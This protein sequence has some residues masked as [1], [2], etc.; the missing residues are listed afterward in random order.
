MAVDTLP[1]WKAL[2]ARAQAV[3]GQHLRAMFA[4]DADRTARFGRR[5]GPFLLDLSRQR[6][7]GQTLGLLQAFA[8]AAGLQ[9]W[10]GRLF[11]GEHVNHTE[12]QAALH[13]ALRVPA[14]AAFVVDGQ[15]LAPAVERERRRMAAMVSRLHAGHWR[16]YS[17]RAIVDIVNIGVGG[18]DL[19]PAMACEAL[20]D[21]THPD[22]QRLRVHFA[23]SMDGSQLDRLLRVLDPETTLFIVSSKSF[24]T[25]DTLAN[26]R[27][28]R[29]WLLA[30][31]ADEALLLRQ[32]FVA[33]TAS[34]DKAKAWGVSEDNLLLF[35]NWVGGRYSLWSTIGLPIAVQ[36]GMSGFR[37]LLAGA[38]F[39][40]EHFRRAPL[41]DNLPVLLGLAGVWNA[42]FL[43]IRAQAVLPYD[44]RLAMFPAYLEQLAMESNGKGVDRDGLQVRYETCPV[45]WGGVGPN[46]QHAFYQLLHQGTVPVTCDFIAPV[47]RNFPVP[48]EQARRELASQHRLALA[49]CLAQASLLALGDVDP[50]RPAWRHYH[51]NQP[52]STLLLDELTPFTLGGLIALYEHKV[53]VESVLWNIN[54]F[55][56]WGVELGKQVARETLA[57]LDGDAGGADPAT[58]ALAAHIRR[59]QQDGAA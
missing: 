42:S 16:G 9:D 38:H 31:C 46:A 20:H 45:L 32:H 55:D 19:G 51:G 6:I 14:D 34:P 41:H 30:H 5:A 29:E 24:S 12:H 15:D 39:V 53:F 49:N 40:D 8:A 7:D 11:A 17:G 13:M 4:A 44:G 18:S 57:M 23:S 47:R 58:R 10:I 28:A 50:S 25:A 21:F 37:E 54:P 2:A 26:A 22:A 36:V 27:T 1:E 56:Q 35:W 59:V 33:V 3:A 52:S 48:G 43:G